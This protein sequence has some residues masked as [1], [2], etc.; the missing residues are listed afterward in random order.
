MTN[1]RASAITAALLLGALLGPAAL[2]AQA[3]NSGDAERPMVARADLEAL[4]S[5]GDAGSAARARQRLAAGDFHGGDRIWL[6][7]QGDTALSDTFT[8]WPDQSLHLPSPTTGSLSLQ[9]V[10]RSELQPKLQQYVARFV[11]NP[12]VRARP[13]M[14]VGIEG[15]VRSAGYYA[16]PADAPLSDVFMAAGGTT[17]NARME[18]AKIVRNG[19]TIMEGRDLEMAMAGGQTLDEVGA[20]EGDQFIMPKKAG[21]FSDGLRFTWLIMSVTLGAIALSKHM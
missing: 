11:R 17:P 20:R 5:S 16:V 19:R 4:A 21:G 3:P 13:L 12:D 9:G 15:E 7:V 8:V 18:K 10:L 2:A 1:P 14:R 6:M